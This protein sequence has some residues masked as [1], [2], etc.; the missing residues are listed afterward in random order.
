LPK[1]ASAAQ[2]SGCEGACCAPAAYARTQP[3]IAAVCGSQLR[4]VSGTLLDAELFGHERGAF[5]GAVR[6]RKGLFEQA[7]GGTLFLDEIGE[8]PA[9]M[10][11]KLLRAVQERVVTRVGGEA[12]IPVDV[13]IICATHCNLKEQVE[14]GAFRAD[15]YYRINVIELKVPPLRERKDDILW[16]AQK[17]VAE[18]NQRHPEESKL[19]S[20]CVEQALLGYSWPGN[21]RELKHSI[22]RACI[23]APLNTI[24]CGDLFEDRALGDVS[25]ADMADDL[26]RYL[27]ACERTHITRALLKHGWKIGNAAAGLGISRKNLWEKMK[28]LQIR[29]ES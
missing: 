1:R 25:V 24:V 9:S 26:N 3:G 29:E 6:T 16:F 15:L 21:I 14:R 8:M 18:Y 12:A 20:P 23:M 17:F 4:S 22:E 5:T 27:Y 11:V 19:F 7:H 13:R 10:Q 28:K 2:G